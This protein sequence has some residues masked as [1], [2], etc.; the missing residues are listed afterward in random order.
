MITENI[1]TMS[2]AETLGFEVT[3]S[4]LTVQVSEGSFVFYR[5]D[6]KENPEDEQTYTEEKTDFPAFSFDV[7]PDDAA[8]G[9]LIDVIYD[10]YLVKDK[11]GN[12]SIHIDRTEYAE[13]NIAFYDGED[14]LLHTLMSIRVP[15]LAESLDN[16]NIVV[17]K[18]R[19]G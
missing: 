8:D 11:D 6:E 14:E 19:R 1:S 15:P 18:I 13:E 7:V 4:G 10:V 17:N 9:A 2:N 5:R 16:A 3:T 12:P